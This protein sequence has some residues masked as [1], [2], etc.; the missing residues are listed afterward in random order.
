MAA[1]KPKRRKSA[2]PRQRALNYLSADRVEDALAWA[3][4]NY[5]DADIENCLS[6]ARIFKSTGEFERLKDLYRH[7]QQIQPEVRA[8]RV[9][10]ACV[11]A[12]QGDEEVL[13]QLLVA[14]GL[15]PL[16]IGEFK[17]IAGTCEDGLRI[18]LAVE[19]YRQ[20]QKL[21]PA[22]TEVSLQLAAALGRVGERAEAAEVLKDL[23]TSDIKDSS[24]A[25]Q[26]WFNLGVASENENLDVAIDAY[27]KALELVPSY[28]APVANLAIL[29]TRQGKFEQAIEFLQPKVA[30]KVDWPRTAV[31]MASAN[32]LN[33][34][35]NV[36]IQILESVV[37]GSADHE[38]NEMVWEMLIRCLIEDGNHALAL[39]RCQAWLQAVPG[40]AIAA[41]MQAA[42]QG[43][44]TPMRA[45]AEYV[46]KTFDSFADS[47]DSVLKNLEYR[48]PQLVG[49]LVGETLGVPAAD[50]IVLDAG[51]GTGLAGPFL[52]PFCSSLTGV[53]L[54]SKMIEQAI[55]RKCYDAL[56]VADLLDYLKAAEN[57]QRFDLIV[58][59][60]TFNYFGDLSELLPACFAALNKDGW[61]VF[62]LEFGD[63]YGETYQ[64]EVHGRYTHPPGYLMEQL[65]A[66]GIEGG[67]MHRAVLRK[68]NGVDVNGLLVAVQKVD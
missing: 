11:A 56:Q 15:T 25:A 27:Q 57:H 39:S 67:E 9:A 68:E 48:A 51:C 29:L 50:R 62:T 36:A 53:D 60:D 19:L 28:E 42:I 49:H 47:F 23:L 20:A 35:L 54:S 43:D 59:A 6:S 46:A 18:D 3:N 33:H 26:A 8:W 5:L 61:L 41:H 58:A 7:L 55:D 38:S 66:C 10:E 1:K 24:V 34:K 30:G 37:G 14:D 65:G 22:D 44:N 13:K 16:A 4:E 32:R 21:D 63:T 64:L 31:L 45:S 12:E 17:L 40:S 52:K 2:L